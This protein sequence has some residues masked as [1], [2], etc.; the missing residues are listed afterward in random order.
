MTSVY[1]TVT[2]LST[3]GYGD[4]FASTIAERTYC[5]LVSPVVAVLDM[6]CGSGRGQR[7][8]VCVCVCQGTRCGP[9]QGQTSGLGGQD[10]SI[11][12]RAFTR[13]CFG[14]L[15]QPTH[16]AKSVFRRYTY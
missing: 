15:F 12:T 10:V 6:V 5:I 9:L 13:T 4:I 16:A 1:W 11:S 3:V 7:L 8:C 14:L 2:T